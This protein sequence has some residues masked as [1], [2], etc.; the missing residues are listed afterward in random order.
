MIRFLLDTV[1]FRARRYL[2]HNPA[3]GAMVIALI[4]SLLTICGSGVV[5]TLDAF[6]GVKWI[7]EIHEVA[8]YATLACWPFTSSASFSQASSTR[9]IS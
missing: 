1:R 2:G 9:K 4:L 8:T 6:W 3:G 5:M 7:E